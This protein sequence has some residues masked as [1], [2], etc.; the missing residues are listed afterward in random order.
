MTPDQYC[1]EKVA[2][3]GSSFYYSFLFLPAERRRAITALYAW[4]R[5]VDDVA[6]DTPRPRAGPPATGLVARRAAQAVRRRADP[7]R[8][9]G[10]APHVKAAGLPHAEMSEVL[11]GMGNGPDPEPVSSDGLA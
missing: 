8:H 2:Q 3:S 10:A 9:A 4:C 7:P 6:D 1:Q 5:E 11:D